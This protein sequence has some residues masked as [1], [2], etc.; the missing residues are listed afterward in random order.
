[1]LILTSHAYN[2]CWA[3]SGGFDLIFH[4]P[5]QMMHFNRSESM[6]GLWLTFSTSYLYL[7]KFSSKSTSNHSVSLSWLL[8]CLLLLQQICQS[9]DCS[10][11]R[12]TNLRAGLRTGF[13]KTLDEILN[14]VN[15]VYLEYF[16]AGKSLETMKTLLRFSVFVACL[17]TQHWPFYTA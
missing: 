7:P 15:L 4:L 14:S 2:H 9:L 5:P 16:G 17:N 13:P 11:I 3:R 10:L 8:S 12:R 6:L 1:M